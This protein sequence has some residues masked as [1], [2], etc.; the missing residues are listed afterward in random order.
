MTVAAMNAAALAEELTRSGEPDPRRFFAA[1]SST[2]DAPWALAVG[3]DLA[4]TGGV[5]PA[6]PPSPL[7]GDYIPRLQAAA[8]ADA[9][10]AA[11]FVRVTSLV[12]PPAALLRPDVVERVNRLSPANV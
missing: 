11:A 2:V 7:A 8:A 12:D 4:F 3:A 1:A 10:L 6:L 5:G 9:D